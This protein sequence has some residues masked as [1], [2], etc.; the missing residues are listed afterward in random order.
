MKRLAIFT[1][2]AWIAIAYGS[3]IWQFIDVGVFS[4]LP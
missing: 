2:L 1:G 4:A 3:V